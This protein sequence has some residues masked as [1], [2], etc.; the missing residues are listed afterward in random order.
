MATVYIALGSNVGDREANFLRAIQLITQ[1]GVAVTKVSSFYETE[2][3]GY[4][5]QPWFLNAALEATTGSLP[6][7]LLSTLR[8]IESHMGSSKPFRNGPRLID[9]DILLYGDAVIDTPA[10]QVPHPRMLQ[11]NF[12][13]AP[14]AEIAPHLRHPSWSAAIADIYAHSPDRSTIRKLPPLNET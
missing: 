12:V 3:V 9:L 10:L 13:L 11:R 7:Q 14:L 6:D 4:L 8:G 1:S 2:P 5:D